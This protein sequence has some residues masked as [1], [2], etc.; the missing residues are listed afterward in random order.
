MDKIAALLTFLL[1]PPG[2]SSMRQ[3]VHLATIE[4]FSSQEIV[5]GGET[6]IYGDG[7]I[8]GEV[9]V[10][11]DG[12]W[13]AGGEHP[14]SSTVVIQGTAVGENEISFVM[15]RSALGDLC[16]PHLLFQGSVSVRMKTGESETTSFIDGTRERMTF[17]ILDLEPSGKLACLDAEHDVDR[18]MG[19]IGLQVDE[20]QEAGLVVTGVVPGRKA[21]AAGFS[22]GDLI[23]VAG[24]MKAYAR[25][26]LLPGPDSG[27]LEVV[28]FRPK[29]G[30]LVSLTLPIRQAAATVN[31]RRN[32]LVAAAFMV[33]V[34]LLQS[35]WVGSALS[36]TLRLRIGRRKVKGEAAA[37]KEA[38]SPPAA[39]AG[40]KLV[41]K[42]TAMLF[43]LVIVFPFVTLVSLGLFTYGRN[44]HAA[45]ACG[46][47]FVL[48]FTAFIGE[49]RDRTG[50]VASLLRRT[51][52]AL[53]VTLP[54]VLVA[55]LRWLQSSSAMLAAAGE[56]QSFY[57]WTWNG[58]QEP[59]S[60]LLLFCGLAAAA[61][62]ERRRTPWRRHV[63]MHLYAIFTVAL[64]VYSMMGGFEAPRFVASYPPQ[65]AMAV[66][67]LIFMSKVLLVYFA[68][69]AVS[70]ARESAYSPSMLNAT[71]IGVL[72][73]VAFIASILFAP[74]VA[75]QVRHL[76]LLTTAAAFA[77]LA[78]AGLLAGRRTDR[79][80]AG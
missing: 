44:I 32:I 74:V 14:V 21:A 13:K 30:K 17:D 67:V 53:L 77:A 63:L 10:V 48:A 46:A 73:L 1:L 25:R 68:L 45:H 27:S 49:T 69:Q 41:D 80:P 2:C 43:S 51:V 33:V 5:L 3:P 29:Q 19:D 28:V 7:F 59:F 72:S 50:A 31:T 9:D 6:R 24:G 16:A 62:P 76:P 64:L 18:F 79:L 12:R 71:I 47:A 22:P 8:T 75:G 66:T 36:R 61:V 58:L 55:V 23:Y 34:L 57:P 60:L 4:Y 39:A 52:T 54:V 42:L 11:F 65:K 15:D 38:A 56:G 37:E 70:V 40:E 78:L 35:R 20:R 26:D